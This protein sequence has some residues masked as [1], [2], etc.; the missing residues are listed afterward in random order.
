VGH[1]INNPLAMAIASLDLMERALSAVL[2]K[3]RARTQSGNHDF[4]ELESP[5]CHLQKHFQNCRSSVDRIRLIVRDL[6][7]L[8]RRPSDERAHVDLG[9]LLESVISMAWCEIEPRAEVV[10]SCEAKV[11]VLGNEARL[12]QVFLNLVVN[13]AQSIPIDGM[14]GQ[15]I[16]VTCRRDGAFAVVEVSD[17]GRGMTPAQRERIF[18]PFFTT[19]GQLGGT[20]LGLAICKEIVESHGGLIDVTSELGRGSSFTVR[21]PITTPVT[22]SES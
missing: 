4:A 1:E 11:S 8:S 13:A 5:L 7:H 18:E 3:V 16:T 6:H 14:D 21:L 20:G 12:G 10:R 17:T 9:A 22:N 19:K 15:S 2:E